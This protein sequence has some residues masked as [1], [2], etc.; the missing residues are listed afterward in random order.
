MCTCTYIHIHTYILP[1]LLLCSSYISTYVL[2]KIA[3]SIQSTPYIHMIHTCRL[4]STPCTY[5]QYNTTGG[6]LT[7]S[8][9]CY[10]IKYL[11]HGT[12]C[13]QTV[14]ALFF[15]TSTIRPYIRPIGVQLISLLKSHSLSIFQTIN[16]H[17][18]FLT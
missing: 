1:S 17:N 9:R 12:F 4:R 15:P 13:S 5:V 16:Y 10:F 2:L 14:V 7:A 6:V 11:S 18:S 8:K 3:Y